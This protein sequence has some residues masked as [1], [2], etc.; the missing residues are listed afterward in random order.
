MG[1]NNINGLSPKVQ[2]AISDGKVTPEEIKGLTKEEKAELENYLKGSGQELAKE[3][4]ITYLKEPK[5][6]DMSGK[7]PVQQAG[8]FAPILWK[9]LVAAGGAVLAFFTQSCKGFG[10]NEDPEP[11]N[12][13]PGN[14]TIIYNNI[15]ITVTDDDKAIVEQLKN[16]NANITALLKEYIEKQEESDRK[17]DAIIAALSYLNVSMDALVEAMLKSGK[18]Q[19]EILAV[20]KNIKADTDAMAK[21]MVTM[22]MSIEAIYTQLK[23]NGATQV[24][25]YEALK[26]AGANLSDV[27]IK[28][29]NL[30]N[31]D[32]GKT[33]LLELIA[34]NSTVIKNALEGLKLSV[35]S[36]KGEY[37][38]VLDD[39]LAKIGEFSSDPTKLKNLETLFEVLIAKVDQ[40]MADNRQFNETDKEFYAA[41]LAKMDKMD[42]DQQAFAESV[43]AQFTK[44]SDGQKA[45]AMELIEAIKENTD[46]AKGTYIVATKI[47]EGMGSLGE[48]ADNAINVLKNL[49]FGGTDFDAE[50]MK[51]FITATVEGMMA[52]FKLQHDKAIKNGDANTKAILDKLQEILDKM[53]EGCKC[54]PS[55]ILAKLEVI[56]KNMEKSTIDDTTHEG[57]IGD[58]GDLFG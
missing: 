3:G 45:N 50:D 39:I 56:I 51:A 15:Q 47:Y 20:L 37:K 46:V 16:D 1:N 48:K 19:D 21:A 36:L 24:Q 29:N 49:S 10:G 7:E 17:L 38:A 44:L 40:M 27:L 35:D 54:E 32:E 23:D 34:G 31:S 58:L 30:E 41:V 4:E 11:P 9:L 52:T 25:I 5:I 13:V 14:S 42:A 26:N 12:K 53:P 28:L 8:F 6:L 43:L 18:T 33:K 55:E 2:Q 57:I 22:N